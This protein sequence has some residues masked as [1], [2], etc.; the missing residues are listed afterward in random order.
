MAK[1]ICAPADLAA[2]QASLARQ[3]IGASDRA[4]GHPDI[5]SQIALRR[6]FGA[7]GKHA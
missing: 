4:D 3:C 1:H 6:Q 2:H 5:V 7:F